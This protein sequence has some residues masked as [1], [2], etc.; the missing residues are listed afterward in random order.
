MK[1]KHGKDIYNIF[2]SFESLKTKFEKT[3]I[4]I[5]YINLCKQEHLLPTF[6]TVP[7]SIKQTITRN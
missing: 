5:E 6:A 1:R 4:D 2:R 7:L 3:K